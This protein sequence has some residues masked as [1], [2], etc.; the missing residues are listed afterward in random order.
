VETVRL[1]ER[2]KER[3]SAFDSSKGALVVFKRVKP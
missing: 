2:A 1:K 3:P